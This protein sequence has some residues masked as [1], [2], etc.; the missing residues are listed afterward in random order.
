MIRA[1]KL[2]YA[3]AFLA[4]PSVAHAQGK[5]AGSP[6]STPKQ[7]RTEVMNAGSKEVKPDALRAAMQ[8]LELSKKHLE[9]SVRAVGRDV[10]KIEA[11][12]AVDEAIKHVKLAEEIANN[13]PK[14]RGTPIGPH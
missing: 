5:T 10:H 13:A 1:N 12:K 7:N 3:F 11:I 8:T 4:L 9:E 2:F 6:A 14:G